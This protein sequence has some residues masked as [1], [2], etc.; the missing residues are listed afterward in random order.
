MNNDRNW[1]LLGYSLWGVGSL[2]FAI[3][4]L[5]DRDELSFVA[6][7]LFMAGIVAVIGQVVRK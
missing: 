6:A 7:V 1:E 4:A 2:L 5:R 3:A